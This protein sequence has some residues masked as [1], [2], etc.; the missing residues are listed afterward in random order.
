MILTPARLQ[1]SRRK[2]FSLQAASAAL[3][4]LPAVRVS[5]PGKWGNPFS[6]ES[7]NIPTAAEAVRRFQQDLVLRLVA[8][9]DLLEP[10]RKKNLAC[11]CKPGE[12]CHADVL[13]D[14][15]NR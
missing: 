15:A 6:V 10:L 11:W 1:L 14:F 12:P 3:N 2:G 13:L 9:P 4:G 5:R 7:P 8:D